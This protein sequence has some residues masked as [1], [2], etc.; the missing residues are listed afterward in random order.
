MLE[1]KVGHEALDLAE[2]LLLLLGGVH[3]IVLVRMGTPPRDRVVQVAL[4]AIFAKTP[5]D[6]EILNALHGVGL[7]ERVV[8]V[9]IS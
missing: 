6:E 9:K 8:Q 7:I 2:H 1:A 5:V 3:G 4:A